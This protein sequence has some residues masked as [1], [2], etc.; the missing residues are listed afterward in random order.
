MLAP[1]IVDLGPDAG[2]REVQIVIRAC[3]AA[4]S[5]GE[6]RAGSERDTPARAFAVVRASD[7]S[8]LVV[9]IEVR[10]SWADEGS[11]LVR[12][13][14]FTRRDPLRER[15]RSVGLAIATLVGESEAKARQVAEA[16]AAAAPA[17]EPVA[18]STAP[19]D[20]PSGSSP[21]ASP[22][23]AAPPAPEAAPARPSP[24]PRRERLPERPRERI[25]E[26]PQSER[27]GGELER[28]EANVTDAPSDDAARDDAARRPVFIGIGVV[29][30]PG[31]GSGPWR[32]GAELNAGWDA[33]SGLWL[34]TT[35]A[36]AWRTSQA[37]FTAQWFSIDAGVGYRGSLG[38]TVSAGA[39]LF[40]GAQRAR[41]E[42]L[43][44]GVLRSEAVW[45]PRVGVVADARW[46]VWPA[47]G[48]WAEARGSS[49]L[50]ESRLLVAPDREPIEGLPVDLGLTA[51]VAWWP[52]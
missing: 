43:A 5:G 10:L 42:I 20:A 37:T 50:R 8:V 44:A 40:A 31:F 41:F 34:A 23:P 36:Y 17:P 39:L 49:L 38:E 2:A 33:P 6:C 24:A 1:V 12:E 51:G 7:E 26:P 30:G 15:W 22:V 48:F 45:N 27:E 16:P 25:V 3:N 52:R 35:L 14:E 18:P 32:L 9:R 11:W 4:V 21:G 13:I 46:Q 19:S 28:R 29:G 47:F